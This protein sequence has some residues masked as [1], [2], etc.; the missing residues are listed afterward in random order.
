MVG[1]VT[2]GLESHWSC[3][4]DSVI[5]V[6]SPTGSVVS[7]REISTPPALLQEYMVY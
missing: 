7:D 4:T 2:V 6:Y 3:V 1:K 5:L